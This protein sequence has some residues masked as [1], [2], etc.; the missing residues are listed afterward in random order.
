MKITAEQVKDLRQRTGAGV[1][2][3]KKALE[4]TSGDMEAAALLLKERGLAK[5]A[6]KATRE[7]SSGHVIAYVHGDPGRIG[8][9]LE[10]NCETDFVART[11]AFRQLARD[12]AMQIAAA[13]PLWVREEDI[14]LEAT[15]EQRQEVIKEMTEARK[16]PEVMQRIVDGK[17]ATWMNEVVLFRQPFIRDS[18]MTVGQ[19]VTG[20]IAEMGEN[21]VVRRFVRYELGERS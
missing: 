11:D 10:I 19:L 3:A 2:D 17:L 9:L 15:E 12:V 8:V 13:N 7:A 20:A 4:E 14:P 1:L 21:I 5:A 18:E 6:K 16:P